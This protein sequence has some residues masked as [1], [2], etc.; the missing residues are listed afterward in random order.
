VV[1]DEKLK[2]IRFAKIDNGELL[3]MIYEQKFLD[4]NRYAIEMVA[5]CGMPVGK[6][7][8]DTCVWIGKFSEG[9]KQVQGNES[10]YIYRKDE[11]INLCQSMKAK[12]CNIRQALIDRFAQHDFKNGKGTKKQPDVFYGFKAD[13]W[14]AMAVATTYYDL[15][16]KQKVV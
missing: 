2:P 15:Y 14:A 1:V 12:D 10:D 11:K 13:I 9:L 7:V 6:E 16:L 3:R 8:F 4:C 5:C